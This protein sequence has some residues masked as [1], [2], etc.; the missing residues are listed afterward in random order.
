MGSSDLVPGFDL[1]VCMAFA[2]LINLFLSHPMGF[3]MSS[4]SLPDPAGGSRQEVV[5][6]LIAGWG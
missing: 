4:S 1:H 6:G 2:F 5:W 3:L